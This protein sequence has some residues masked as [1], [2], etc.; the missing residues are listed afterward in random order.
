MESMMLDLGGGCGSK[1]R[2]SADT[3]K[4]NVGWGVACQWHGQ[5]GEYGADF[6]ILQEFFRCWLD[7]L[8]E[9]YDLAH[10]W[11]VMA[12]LT[13]AD[14]SINLL[15]LVGEGGVLKLRSPVWI[16]NKLTIT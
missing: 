5:R 7:G 6:R 11:L 14:G 2:K 3:A 1:D 12:S 10:L 8:G 16:S 13:L 4:E 9:V 15:T